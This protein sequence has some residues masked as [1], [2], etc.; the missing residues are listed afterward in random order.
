MN[1]INNQEL[2]KRER[3]L[4]KQEQ[5]EKDRSK[6]IQGKKL[7]KIIIFSSLIL[8][9]GGVVFGLTNYS[10]GESEGTPRIE[11]N[12]QKYDAGTVSMADGLVKK[13]YEIKN[14]GDGD[15]KIDRIWTSC[16]CTTAILKVGDE[17]S[18]IFKM[19]DNPIFWSQK[20]I[21]GETGF[22]ELTFDP[23]FHAPQGVGP[24]LRA[25]YLSTNDPQNEKAEARLIANV[26]R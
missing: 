10:P 3:Y 16:M 19:H 18:P 8:I 24:I 6:R 4:L 1:N 9:I 17:E 12:P 5:K 15:L 25:I 23:A 14:N 26:V 2:T 7:R 13:T 20:I 21:P 11:I 22:L